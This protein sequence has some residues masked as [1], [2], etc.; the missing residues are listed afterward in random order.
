MTVS[1]KTEMNVVTRFTTGDEVNE[2]GNKRIPVTSKLTLGM[3]ISSI[4][5]FK[6]MSG[7]F[8]RIFLSD[9][10]GYSSFYMLLSLE[11]EPGVSVYNDALPVEH[12]K[13]VLLDMFM[14]AVLMAEKEYSTELQ[15]FLPNITQEPLKDLLYAGLEATWAGYGR[16]LV[17][18]KTSELRA[19]LTPTS[20]FV[21][22][23]KGFLRE[24]PNGLSLAV[25]FSFPRGFGDSKPQVRGSRTLDK[26]GVPL[27]FL[28]HWGG[29]YGVMY[30]IVGDY[31]KYAALRNGT[32][33][34]PQPF[35]FNMEKSKRD[36]LLLRI[37]KRLIGG[38]SWSASKIIAGFG[39]TY[40]EYLN[41]NPAFTSITSGEIAGLYHDITKHRTGA[42]TDKSDI[43]KTALTVLADSNAN[44]AWTAALDS[45]KATSGDV[46]W[47]GFDGKA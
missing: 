32:E 45:S 3:T 1:I 5:E 25:K 33:P 10:S 21:P 23:V 12:I 7:R 17:R 41:I 43:S 46:G 42:A 19:V 22:P 9:S 39:E 35:G 30:L 20:V 4:D 13:D 31:Q 40:S 16:Y 14:R 6:P 47:I 36:S 37:A 8:P 44:T 18:H 24:G 2:D 27:P 28:L 29:R 26:L 34:V 15:A 11:S 38:G